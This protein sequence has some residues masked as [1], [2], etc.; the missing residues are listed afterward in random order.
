MEYYLAIK[1]N[2]IL[3]FATT[4]MELKGIRLSQKK[5]KYDITYILYLKNTTQGM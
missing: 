5:T 4:W 2:E 1:N 3:P